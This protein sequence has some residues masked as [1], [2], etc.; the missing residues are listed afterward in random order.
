LTVYLDLLKDCYNKV[1]KHNSVVARQKCGEAPYELAMRFAGCNLSCGLCFASGY[2]WPDRFLKAK[3]VTGKKTVE[4]AISD[5]KQIPPPQNHPAYNWFR[6][7]GGEPFLNDEYTEFL[8]KILLKI[9]SIEST[10]FNNGIIIQTN[11]IHLGK[12]NTDLV[13]SYLQQLYDQNPSVIVAIETSI[14]GTNPEEFKLLTRTQSDELF[15]WNINSYFNLRRLGLPNLRPM[16]VAGFGVNESF[17]LK[18]ENSK[19]RMTIISREN[20]PCFH[21]SLWSDDFRRLY[22]DFTNRAQTLDP[23]FA[24][25]PMYGIGDAF[26]KR[27]VRPSIDQG[28]RIYANRFYDSGDVTQRNNELEDSF[29]EIIRNFFLVDNQTYYSAMIKPLSSG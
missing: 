5:F 2:S 26:Y 27:W 6:V 25:M 23:M 20:V 28:K 16:I 1:G 9:S 18:G 11:G 8:L 21:P 22:E 13:R 24:K 17:L 29:K 4:D 14:K 7:L 15:K 19:F 10:K 12:G 3:N